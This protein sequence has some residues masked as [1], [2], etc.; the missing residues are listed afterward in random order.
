MARNKK[1]EEVTMD[2]PEIPV[3]EEPTTEEQIKIATQ[4]LENKVL[5]LTYTI[6]KKEQEIDR[7]NRE[8]EMQNR[9]YERVITSLVLTFCG[10]E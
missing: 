8:I 10:K 7:L 4:E 5:D 3:P 2:F 1:V 9:K 6:Y